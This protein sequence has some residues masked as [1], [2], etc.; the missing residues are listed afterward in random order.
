MTREERLEAIRRR[1]EV[2]VLIVGG[3]INGVDLLRELALEGV[4]AVPV[5]KSDFC[6]GAVLRRRV[7]FTAA[8]GTSRTASFAWS[9]N[10]CGSETACSRMLF[11]M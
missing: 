2:S 3:G 5:E 1:P 11:I 6:S 4:D 7:S 10:L 8:H 9:G